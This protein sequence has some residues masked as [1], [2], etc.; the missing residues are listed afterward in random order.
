MT[1][2]LKEAIEKLQKGWRP[3]EDSAMDVVLDA[4]RKWSSIDTAPLHDRDRTIEQLRGELDVNDRQHKHE[5][6]Q[7]RANLKA[8]QQAYERDLTEKLKHIEELDRMYDEVSDEAT[9]KGRRIA[10]LESMLHDSKR[11]FARQTELLT[12][13][14]KRVAEMRDVANN[15]IGRLDAR[16][17]PVTRDRWKLQLIAHLASG[18]SVYVGDSEDA[19]LAIARWEPK[20]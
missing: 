17:Q 9:E 10:T 20:P 13:A 15:A 2:E 4:A 18:E 1:T 8:N 19:I 5:R 16:A 6:E 3:A 12:A 11:A 14:E 7:L